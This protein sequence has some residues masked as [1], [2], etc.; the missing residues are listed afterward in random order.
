MQSP[1]SGVSWRPGDSDDDGD[2]GDGAVSCGD[3]VDDEDDWDGETWG[4]CED[5]D[6]DE[7]AFETR[8]DGRRGRCFER[9]DSVHHEDTGERKCS[10]SR[11][12]EHSSD[13]LSIDGFSGE[14]KNEMQGGVSD[15]LS[16]MIGMDEVNKEHENDVTKVR[17]LMQWCDEN[18]H[19]KPRE[20]SSLKSQ[21][22]SSDV[23]A[24]DAEDE[25]DDAESN[26]T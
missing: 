24:L 25:D 2:E 14:E 1:A 15:G 23:V 10:K 26:F 11:G 6:D 18:M 4:D 5:D 7:D 16:S 12:S 20:M 8:P 22:E 17:E 13:I 21:S 9:R 3:D 19:K